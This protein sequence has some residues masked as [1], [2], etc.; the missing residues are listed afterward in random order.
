MAALLLDN[1]ALGQ[2][3]GTATLEDILRDHVAPMGSN[4]RERPACQR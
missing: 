3:Y 4:W 2:D 1:E